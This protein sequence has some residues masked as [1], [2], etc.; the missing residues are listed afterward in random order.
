MVMYLYVWYKTLQGEV[1]YRRSMKG[2]GSGEEYYQGKKYILSYSESKKTLVSGVMAGWPCPRKVVTWLLENRSLSD[3]IRGRRKGRKGD[4]RAEFY[5]NGEKITVRATPI[6]A[7]G[8][9]FIYQYSTAD[10]RTW[11]TLSYAEAQKEWVRTASST[12][13]KSDEDGNSLRG[14]YGHHTVRGGQCWHAEQ[15][16]DANLRE[17]SVPEFYRHKP[18]R[19]TPRAVRSNGHLALVGEIVMEH[20]VSDKVVKEAMFFGSYLV[21]GHK[22]GQTLPKTFATPKGLPLPRAPPPTEENRGAVDN[23]IALDRRIWVC[24][25]HVSYAARSILIELHESMNKDS[26]E[27]EE[28][29][30][31]F[32]KEFKKLSQAMDQKER[33]KHAKA[34]AS[35]PT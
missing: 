9:G 6:K 30:N 11:H 8:G 7:P 16:Q 13:L 25:N 17:A 15:P 31:R 24:C 29:I 27:L 12:H 5:Q 18:R 32:A 35:S 20:Y 33:G 1:Y 22:E 10:C 21:V 28:A 23:V 34:S 4:G 14:D 19:T 26:R 2:G 3:L